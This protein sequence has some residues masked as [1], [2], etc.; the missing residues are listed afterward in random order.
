MLTELYEEARIKEQ[1]D[2][3]TISVLETAYPPEIKY[4]PNRS[5]IVLATFFASFILAV[6][7]SLFADYLEN[8]RRTSP[9]DFELIDQ[10]RKKFTGKTGYSDS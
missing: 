7:I 3:P 1:K 4:K 2:T 10:A 9:S 8:L 5:I 6:F